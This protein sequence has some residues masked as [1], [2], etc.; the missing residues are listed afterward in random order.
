[1]FVCFLY[2]LIFLLFIGLFICLFVVVV[3]VS[4]VVFVFFLFSFL[5][6]GG[7]GGGLSY[8][9]FLYEWPTLEKKQYR[10]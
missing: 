5:R 9:F 8:V 10:F 3:V 7:E 1:V 2:G 6:W 4:A